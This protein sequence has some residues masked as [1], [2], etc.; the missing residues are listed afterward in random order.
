VTITIQMSPPSRVPYTAVVREDEATDGTRLFLAEIPELPGCQS[1]GMTPEE[2]LRNVEEAAELYLDVAAG[3]APPPSVFGVTIT[4]GTSMAQIET[5]TEP[6][7]IEPEI[8]FER[9][10]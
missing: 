5:T 7:E 3:E 2:A 8:T 9:V 10:A 6:A 1:H 4:V